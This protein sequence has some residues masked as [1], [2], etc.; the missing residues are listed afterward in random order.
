MQAR[1]KTARGRWWSQL[2]CHHGK[3]GR[4]NCER[5]LE[6]HPVGS[7]LIREKYDSDMQILSRVIATTDPSNGRKKKSFSH[8]TLIENWEG[9]DEDAL[10]ATKRAIEGITEGEPILRENN[11]CT[12]P[13]TPH[14]WVSAEEA[15]MPLSSSSSPRMC[16]SPLPLFL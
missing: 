16:F 11:S 9:K 13:L 5:I 2:P 1:V 14:R 3:I 10:K 12:T 4:E 8:Q 6:G 15:W 7:Y